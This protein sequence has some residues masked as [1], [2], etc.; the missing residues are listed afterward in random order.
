D[1]N[2]GAGDDGCNWQL[3]CDPKSVNSKCPYDQQY[4]TQHANE[5]SVSGSQSQQCINFCRKFV[6][7]G[8]DCFGCCLIPGAPTPIKLAS[9]C[10]AGDFVNPTNGTRCT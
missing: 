8:C 3:K 2:S 5:C 10:I 7:N 6:P 1:G 9:T 4:A